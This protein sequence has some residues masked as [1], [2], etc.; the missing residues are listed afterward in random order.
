M[1]L[2]ATMDYP[3]SYFRYG[4]AELPFTSE[5]KEALI[6]TVPFDYVGL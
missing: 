5:F 4:F 6:D 2:H 3:K 1:F